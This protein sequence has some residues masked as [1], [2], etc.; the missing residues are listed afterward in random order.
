M[1]A[2]QRG[3][4]SFF[5]TGPPRR[6][7]VALAWLLPIAAIGL[8]SYWREL[9][10]LRP[11]DRD[12]HA[13]I[14]LD[15]ALNDTYCHQPG[16]LA[17]NTQ[18]LVGLSLAADPS[19]MHV[20]FPELLQR[21][22]FPWVT[23]CDAVDHPF[24]NN[25]NSTML[26]MDAIL[27]LAPRTTPAAL[28]LALTA[29]K[30]APL[31]LFTFVLLKTGA[32]GSVAF[33]VLL[34][35]LDIAGDL[36]A[37]RY[38]IY[39]FL[40]PMLLLMASLYSLWLSTTQTR[41]IAL[42]GVTFAVAGFLTAFAANLRTSHLPVYLAM[43]LLYAVALRRRMGTSPGRL[44]YAVTALVLFAASYALFNRALISRLVPPAGTVTNY[45]HHPIAHPLVL[46]LGVPPHP[47]S[48][49]EGITWDDSVGPKLAQ[50]MIPDAV[51]LGRH[52]E[53]ALLLYYIKLWT[54]YPSEMRDLYQHK[55]QLAG[56]G[57]FSYPGTVTEHQ[58]VSARL[59]RFVRIKDGRTIL[60]LFAAVFALAVAGYAST[61][62]ALAAA[63]AFLS[64]AAI[65]LFFEAAAIMP[66]FILTYHSYLLWFSAFTF[67]GVLQAGAD[68]FG[69]AIRRV[70]RRGVR[71][72]EPVP[73][74]SSDG[75]QSR[76]IADF[77]EQWT[78]FDDNSGYYGSAALFDDVFAPFFTA[79]NLQGKA[80]AEIGSGS[81]RW[82]R[83]FLDA[84]AAHVI[85]LE[86]SAAMQ[87]LERTFANEPARVAL[88]HAPGDQ[89]P[90]RADR[91]YV[92]SIGVLHHI[93]EPDP[94][95]RAALGALKPGGTFGVWLYGREG[96]AMYL[97]VFGA[98]HGITRRLPHRGLAAVSWLLG[99]GLD[100]Y[101]AACR[102]LPLPLRGYAQNVLAKLSR[103]KRRLVI[104]DQLNPAYAKYYTRA[105]AQAL[106][107][108]A[109]CEDIRV[110]HRHGYSWTVVGRKPS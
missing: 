69:A 58:H 106:L 85:A 57:L 37:F 20:P 46:S 98:L 48:V 90:A 49:R 55:L 52:Y 54:L 101:I 77:G 50:R 51:Y 59:S 74:A 79:G 22:A 43:F 65:L 24:L 44:V 61:S 56:T 35:G 66:P 34:I 105:E 15:L 83:V 30:L 84:G 13:T 39:G 96:N 86:P 2:L 103:D 41:R 73:H 18:Q 70:A 94:V 9:T 29:V 42:A 45:T 27:H 4:R 78:T 26:L 97:T 53:E 89:L 8:A 88:M 21:R 6:A 75:L 31:V 3:F 40:I 25:E 104:Y 32:P 10:T 16:R 19:L 109:G 60:A 36:E 95:C 80:I 5:F 110:H 93:P 99:W 107:A 38:S 68:M 17:S 100:A 76:T 87:V 14:A 91:D 62:R 28:G 12:W 81:G 102:I 11:F 67:V 72:A 1:N 108:R 47:L 23:Y 71:R 7:R 63:V 33:V 92:F 64:L 82:V